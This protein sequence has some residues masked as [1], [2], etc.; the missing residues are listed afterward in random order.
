MAHTRL[1][2][3]KTSHRLRETRT[4]EPEKA[5]RA[6]AGSGS[7]GYHLENR[8]GRGCV[9]TSDAIRWS[10]FS[11][12]AGRRGLFRTAKVGVWPHRQKALLLKT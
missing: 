4:A 9:T 6:S 3:R 5:E 11:A 8:P 1:R 2:L 10:S 7:T 12:V